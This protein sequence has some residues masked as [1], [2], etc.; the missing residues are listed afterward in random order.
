MAQKVYDQRSLTISAVIDKVCISDSANPYQ[1]GE[2]EDVAPSKAGSVP[3]V[4]VH[5]IFRRPTPLFFC[6]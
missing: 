1:L 4:A 2:G 3:L 5:R 6:H